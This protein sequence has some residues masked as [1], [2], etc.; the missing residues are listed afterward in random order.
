MCLLKQSSWLNSQWLNNTVSRL[1]LEEKNQ[2]PLT[3]AN[4]AEIFPFCDPFLRG[5]DD[6]CA[7]VAEEELN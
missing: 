6:I 1:Y 3:E 7:S 4:K 2:R 5:M